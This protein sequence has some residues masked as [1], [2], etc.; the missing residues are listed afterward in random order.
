MFQILFRTFLSKEKKHQFVPTGFQIQRGAC[1]DSKMTFF[2]FCSI[3]GGFFVVG[4]TAFWKH[5][6]R[7]AISEKMT[8]NL[9]DFHN[10]G[11]H[12]FDCKKRKKQIFFS[13]ESTLPTCFLRLN[14]DILSGTCQRP[15][16]SGGFTLKKKAFCKQNNCH[17]D[18]R[19]FDIYEDRTKLGMTC[20]TKVVLRGSK[21]FHH[22]KTDRGPPYL[23][24]YSDVYLH[25]IIFTHRP[26][27]KP[28]KQICFEL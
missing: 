15:L 26:T 12:W 5:F 23:R 28:N 11:A 7:P 27:C 14:I 21:G 17:L 25:I 9:V 8:M 24:M 19:Y 2:F 3:F 1:Q 6:G 18:S 4:T 10:L 13:W 20:M 16:S 22:Y